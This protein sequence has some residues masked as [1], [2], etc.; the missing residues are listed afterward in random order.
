M[1]KENKATLVTSTVRPGIQKDPVKIT[2]FEPFLSELGGSMPKL[3][4]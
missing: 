1:I 2:N 3:N 4:I